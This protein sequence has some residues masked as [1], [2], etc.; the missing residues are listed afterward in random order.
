MITSR[1]SIPCSPD[2]RTSSPTSTHTPV[3]YNGKLDRYDVI[4]LYDM[5][6]GVA[7][8]A[9]SPLQGICRIGQRT[10][11]PA[12]R[13][14]SAL[15]TGPWY[16]ETI[17]AQYFEKKSTYKHDVELE[18]RARDTAS[19]TRGVWA[20]ST[21]TMKPYK[22]MWMSDKNTILLR[23]THPTSDGP[24]AWISPYTRS[25]VVTDSARAQRLG[26]QVTGVAILGAQRHTMGRRSI[27]RISA[28]GACDTVPL[29][30]TT[31]WSSSELDL[32]APSTN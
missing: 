26:A 11:R 2:R 10:R 16:R 4:V 13:L 25:R 32:H 28:Q 24:V 1:R 17:G 7:R 6:Q 3:A 22:G 12:S 31:L 19:D 21:S 23:T 20:N 30:A 27:T 9:K 29:H 5:V 8:G 18:S 15:R 14:S